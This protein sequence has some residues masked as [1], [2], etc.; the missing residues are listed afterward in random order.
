MIPYMATPPG[1][2]SLLQRAKQRLLS[3][4]T[5]IEAAMY[6]TIANTSPSCQR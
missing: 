4:D 3:D 5:G 1:R 6:V 2:V